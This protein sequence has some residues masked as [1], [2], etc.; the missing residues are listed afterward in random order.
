MWAQEISYRGKKNRPLEIRKKKGSENTPGERREE[1]EWLYEREC[2]CERA[3]L[4]KKKRGVEKVM[5]MLKREK[6][7]TEDFYILPKLR[8]LRGGAGGES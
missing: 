8:D 5:S 3:R 6:A 4:E 2:V 1:R 7:N